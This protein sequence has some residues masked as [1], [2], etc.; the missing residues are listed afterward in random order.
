[1]EECP[2]HEEVDD[3]VVLEHD[4]DDDEVDE[5]EVMV[6]IYLYVLIVS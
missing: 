5:Q 1:M 4:L 3:E 6:E 2:Q